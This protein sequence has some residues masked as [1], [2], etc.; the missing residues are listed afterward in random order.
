MSKN[1][2]GTKVQGLVHVETPKFE[3]K[4]GAVNLQ[5]EKPMDLSEIQ[6]MARRLVRVLQ[7]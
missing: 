4:D 2:Q 6:R 5:A 3:G 7:R 1:L